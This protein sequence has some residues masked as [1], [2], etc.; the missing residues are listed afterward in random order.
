MIKELPPTATIAVLILL[1]ITFL[2]NAYSTD[3]ASALMACAKQS[4]GARVNPAPICPTP[5]SL[6]AMPVLMIGRMLVSSTYLVRDA[7]V[8]DRQDVGVE[9]L[10]G[11]YAGR[12]ASEVQW[13]QREGIVAP[14]RDV[15]HRHRIGDR[16]IWRAAH[17]LYDCRRR[18]HGK[19]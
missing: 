6:C 15:G 19:P 9:H 17:E 5:A 7:G 14:E 3:A 10:A 8:D 11:I 16:V 2:A 4:S 12:R 18:R 13:R 1:S